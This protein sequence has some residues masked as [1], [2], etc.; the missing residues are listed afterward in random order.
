M[1]NVKELLRSCDLRPTDQRLMVGKLLFD[2]IDKHVS[3]ESIYRDLKKRNE[4]ISLATVYNILHDFSNK[5]LLEKVIIDPEKIY[6]DTNTSSHYHFYYDDKKTLTDI[7]KENI[8][9]NSLPEAPK[10][11]SIK[12][13]EIIIHLENK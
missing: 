6:F 3:A 1:R 4:K 9:I 5:K 2:G 7:P 8:V 13:I 10:G 11:K 12:N